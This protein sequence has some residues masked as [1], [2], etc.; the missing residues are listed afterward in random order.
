MATRADLRGAAAIRREPFFLHPIVW[1]GV[2]LGVAAAIFGTALFFTY[3]HWNWMMGE[4]GFMEQ[5]QLL[6]LI[7]ALAVA[8]RLVAMPQVK[9]RPW[10][11][12]W[13][14][15][16]VI[17]CLYTTVEEAS[18]GQHIIG[19]STPEGWRAINQQHETNL[20]NVDNW[21]D[22]KPR[23]LLELAAIFGGIIAPIVMYFRPSLKRRPAALILPTVVCLP[24]ALL[25]ELSK[26]AERIVERLGF[27]DPEPL[28]G[29]RGN[30]VQE[31]F[32]YLFVLFYLL[33]LG[34]KIRTEAR[35]RDS[36]AA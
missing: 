10:L 21:F 3:F 17:G 24:S 27:E 15:L 7:I 18:Y 12:A 33:D 32:F 6:T 14:V 11:R 26:F 4:L 8:I 35:H 36:A 22:M 1:L 16:A 19:W 30:E 23:L 9:G 29:F 2:P 31:S 20:H 34:W 28:L 25:A 13:L 5:A